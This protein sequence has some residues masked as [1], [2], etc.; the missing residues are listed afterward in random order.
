MNLL[1]QSSKISIA[2]RQ[3]EAATTNIHPCPTIDECYNAPFEKKYNLLFEK[4]YKSPMGPDGEDIMMP[5]LRSA[6]MFH[7]QR[8]I[9][10]SIQLLPASERFPLSQFQLR[11][12]GLPNLCSL[13]ESDETVVLRA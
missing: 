5:Q 13:A 3:E 1:V 11:H 12:A 10:C 4:C 6:T 7:L 2:M 8:V 9:E